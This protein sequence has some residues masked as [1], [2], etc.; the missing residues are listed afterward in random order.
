MNAKKIRPALYKFDT[1][2]WAWVR[3]SELAE[4]VGMTP[5]G[6]WAQHFSY[7]DGELQVLLEGSETPIVFVDWHQWERASG[8]LA[9]SCM[10]P[11]MS[12]KAFVPAGCVKKVF[13]NDFYRRADVIRRSE[14]MPNKGYCY[15]VV[16]VYNLTTLRSWVKAVTHNSDLE[17]PEI[18]P[19]DLEAFKAGIRPDG[20][21]AANEGMVEVHGPESGAT[22]WVKI[23]SAADIA[24]RH[25]KRS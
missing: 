24:C 23:G 2:P 10:E 6:C 25:V 15:R 1:L 18:T 5:S 8:K 20:T 16:R 9:P 21:C 11:E 19:E 17:I 4:C 14:E 12:E 7:L 22:R 13:D 3:L